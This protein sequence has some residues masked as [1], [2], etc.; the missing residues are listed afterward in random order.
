MGDLLSGLE[1][2]GL[3]SID[4]DNL[5]EDEPKKQEAEPVK[6]EVKK[7]DDKPK[8]QDY[9]LQKTV[10][11]PVCD[12]AFQTIAVKASKARR[13]GAD[14]DLRPHFLGIDT[15]KY[16]ITSCPYCGYTSMN[17]YFP[18]LSPVQIKLIKE[19]VSSKF[20]PST[21]F[22]PEVFTY[23]Y[24]L[25]KYKLSLYNTVVKRGKVSEKAYTCLNMAWLCRGKAEEMLASGMDESSQGVQLARKE[26]MEYYQQAY[27]GMI[28]AVSAE[29]FPICGM[30]S[31]TMDML[32]AQ[33][34]FTLGKY[35]MASK[36]V[37]RLLTSGTANRNVKDK[38]LDLK[39]EI[40]ETLKKGQG[41]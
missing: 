14:R 6:E 39:E 25:D 32:L 24:A 34:S 9:L 40:I 38:A 37:S 33:M 16:N 13:V 36:L 26:E 10:N 30:D 17:K 5:F 19:G 35:E 7:Q 1:K 21:T 18:H 29:S 20:Q 4:M 8:E 15:L 27:D 31:N 23:E 3:G 12:H 28:K 41:I 2:F 22:L 11:C